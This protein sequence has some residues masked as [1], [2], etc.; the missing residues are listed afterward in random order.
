MTPSP[1]GRLLAEH[2]PSLTDHTFSDTAVLVVA[3]DRIIDASVEDVWHW[4][5]DPLHTVQ[6]YGPWHR[7]SDQGDIRIQLAEG[8]GAPALDVRVLECEPGRLL[9]VKLR[10]ARATWLTS[11]SLDSDPKRDD[12]PTTLTCV[13]SFGSAEVLERAGPAYDFYLD[14][15][16]TAI[17]GGDPDGIHFE[18]AYYP[19]LV[20]YYRGLVREAIATA[21]ESRELARAED[22]SDN[23]NGLL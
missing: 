9:R 8:P 14:R 5:V 12:S 21:Q 11:I 19:D 7:I 2:M 16:A 17:A 15:L 4:L 6:W 20:P 10:T 22:D 13:Q 1:S 3:F 23:G 18:P